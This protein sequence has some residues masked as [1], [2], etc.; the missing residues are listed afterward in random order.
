MKIITFLI[1][2]C[3][4]AKCEEFDHLHGKRVVLLGEGFSKIDY[5][6]PERREILIVESTKSAVD[7]VEIAKKF[8][9]NKNKINVEGV[10]T[11]WPYS[12]TII[13]NDGN[14]VLVASVKGEN[15]I[16]YAAIKELKL[17][18]VTELLIGTNEIG[19]RNAKK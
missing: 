3:G 4:I 12:I 19:I 17:P 2:L 9:I 18:R 1:F 13:D 6:H 7:I 14:Q 16:Q 8:I 11:S 5:H 15:N 10:V